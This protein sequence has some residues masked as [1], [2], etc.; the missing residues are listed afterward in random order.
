MASKKF[1]N[2]D[3]MET[4]SKN[5]GVIDQKVAENFLTEIFELRTRIDSYD[6]MFEL[7]G[8]P[9]LNNKEDVCANFFRSVIMSN[10]QKYSG[11][12]VPREIF[13]KYNY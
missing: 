4:L 10:R 7:I 9:E 13:V 5:Y 1:I 8:L 3:C 2:G 11:I 6:K 12:Y